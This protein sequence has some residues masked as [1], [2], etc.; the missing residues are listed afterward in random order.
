MNDTV[1]LTMISCCDIPPT[2]SQKRLVNIT[3]FIDNYLC[4]YIY[5]ENI[6]NRSQTGALYIYIYTNAYINKYISG[7]CVYKETLYTFYH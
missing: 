4:V 5:N 6:N 7:G 1:H 3:E 2:S